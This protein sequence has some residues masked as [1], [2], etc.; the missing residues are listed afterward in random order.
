N[1]IGVAPG[2]MIRQEQKIMFLLPGPYNE[3]QHMVNAQV[4]PF[5]QKHFVKDACRSLTISLFGLP[6]ADV[7]IGLRQIIKDDKINTYVPV[8]FSIIADQ[9]IVSITISCSGSDEHAVQRTLNDMQ[10]KICRI[11]G[12]AV[13]DE[14]SRNLQEAAAKLCI[15]CK[16]TLSIA[17]SCTGGGVSSLLTSI[18]GS[19]NF[20]KQGLIVYSNESKIRLLG[21]AEDMLKEH[22]A[23]SAQTAYAMAANLRMRAGTDYAVSLT[24]IAGPGSGTALKKIGLVYIG[25][26]GPEG[27][28]VKEFNFS[29][30]RWMIQKQAALNALDMLR[31]TLKLK[32]RCF[33]TDNSSLQAEE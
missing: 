11:F 29:G 9:L 30:D 2:M 12:D 33:F 32:R 20:F 31:K 17:E 4:I 21:V 24:G 28:E 5:L 6:E 15:R 22:G 27:T 25:L 13:L 1:E 7:D 10:L 3:M 26:A 19:S 23:V 16:K 14:G 8:R 18:P